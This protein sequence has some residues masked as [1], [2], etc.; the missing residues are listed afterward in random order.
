LCDPLGGGPRR[1]ADPSAVTLDDAINFASIMGQKGAVVLAK[2]QESGMIDSDAVKTM[3]ILDS[4][5]RQT[6]MA[7]K[8]D[9]LKVR[10]GVL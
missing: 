4:A 8:M 9:N 10:C 7:S 5:I 1:A 2:A 6:T 3:A